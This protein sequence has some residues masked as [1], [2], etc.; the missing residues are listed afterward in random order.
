MFLNNHLSGC[1]P[2]EIG[3]L[4]KATVF[5]IATNMITGTIPKSLGCLKKIEQL[6]LANNLLYGEVPEVVCQLPSLLNLTLAGNYFT[7]LPYACKK[8]IAR[9]KLDVRNNCFPGLPKQRS[10][11]ECY[12]F[13]CT[14]KTCPVHNYV[15]CKLPCDSLPAT[16][17]DSDLSSAL[18]KK[19]PLRP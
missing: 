13:A 8:L 7:S 10:P 17:L 15:P 4:K 2:Y 12:K 11:A 16:K 18:W 3:F 14:H 19:H 6:N 5:D 1:L 9:K